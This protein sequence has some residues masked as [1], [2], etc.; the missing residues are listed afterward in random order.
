MDIELLAKQMRERAIRIEVE[1]SANT[2]QRKSRQLPKLE[3]KSID[4]RIEELKRLYFN[5]GRWSGG[6][7]DHKARMAFQQIEKIDNK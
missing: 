5:A 4:D 1:Q 3:Y 6:S 7:R 2:A